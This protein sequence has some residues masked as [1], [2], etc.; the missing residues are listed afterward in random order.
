MNNSKR[1]RGTRSLIMDI[2][3]D[4]PDWNA[5]QIHDRY[6]I[7]IG[8]TRQAVTLN[9]VQKH[10]QELRPLLEKIRESGLDNPWHMGLL[11]DPKFRAAHPELTA[12]AL[13]HIFE[14]Q[15]VLREILR[16]LQRQVGQEVATEVNP[17]YVPLPT[18]QALWV[19]R[20]YDVVNKHRDESLKHDSTNVDPLFAVSWNYANYEFFCDLA[21]IACDT[22]ELD[23]ALSKGL[24]Y[25]YK[26]AMKT[27]FFVDADFARSQ[28]Q[29]VFGEWHSL[30]EQIFGGK[31][32]ARELKKTEAK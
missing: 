16:E 24:A 28:Q 19:A 27:N 26:F 32:T 7:V 8:D 23:V 17:D 15:E 30:Y 29:P 2:L 3:K 11:T 10:L 22:S 6:L 9:A 20:L 14:V 18:R 4:H 12:E 21:G 13:S 31:Q 1:Q 5:K 25:F